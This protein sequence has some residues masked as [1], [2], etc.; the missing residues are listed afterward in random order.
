MTEFICPNCNFTHTGN[1]GKKICPK[2]KTEMIANTNIKN[3]VLGFCGKCNKAELLAEVKLK[4]KI[5]QSFKCKMNNK[6]YNKPLINC[7]A[8]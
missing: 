2:C 1:C 8:L 7:E 4:D 3:K 5:M 6:I